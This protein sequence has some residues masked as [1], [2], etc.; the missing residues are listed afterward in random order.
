MAGKYAFTLDQGA[1]WDTSLYI[2]VDGSPMDLTGYTARMQARATIPD[3]TVI[4]S[5]TSDGGQLVLGGTAGTVILNVAD[6]ITAAYPSGTFVY[7]L[8]LESDTGRT[9]RLLQGPFTITPEV[10]R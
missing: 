10:T 5:W 7:D 3:D 8:E 2:E 1:T 9:M 4:F 6:T